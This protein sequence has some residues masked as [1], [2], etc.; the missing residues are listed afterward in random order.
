LAFKA[1]ILNALKK[2]TEAMEIIKVALQKNI[3]NF[4]CW[5]VQG[6]LLKGQKLYKEAKASYMMAI[7]Y[8]ESN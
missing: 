2:K 5:H 1:L 8:D 4:T 3:K 7:K 6:I